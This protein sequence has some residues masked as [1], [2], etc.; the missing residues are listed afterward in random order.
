MTRSQGGRPS[1]PG[2][3]WSTAARADVPTGVTPRAS[4]Q[5]HTPSHPDWMIGTVNSAPMLALTAV[6]W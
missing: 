2:V 1:A 4:A 6:G 3:Q 5:R